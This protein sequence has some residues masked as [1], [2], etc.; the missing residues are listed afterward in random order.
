MKKLTLSVGLIAAMLSSNAQDT[1]CTYFS[2]KEVF[3]FNYY[4]DEVIS[5]EKQTDKFY[6]INIEYGDILCLDLSDEKKRVR[7]VIV[8]FWDGEKIEQVLDSENNV[9]Y[10]PMGVTRVLVGRPKLFCKL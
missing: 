3:E 1:L 7:K 6:E 10:S 8:E 2:G 9:Y 4:T 5:F